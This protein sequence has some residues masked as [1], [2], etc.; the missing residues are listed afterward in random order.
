MKWLL[1]MLPSLLPAVVPHW[2]ASVCEVC[3]DSQSLECIWTSL[4]FLPV[5]KS[6]WPESARHIYSVVYVP[7]VS[8]LRGIFALLDHFTDG[9]LNYALPCRD[10]VLED[11]PRTQGLASNSRTAGGQNSMALALALASR[12]SGLGLELV[13]PWPRTFCPR[14]HPAPLSLRTWRNLTS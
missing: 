1:S 14:I 6:G 8:A 5:V 12:L 9:L 4:S 7:C 13:Q 10:G 3:C 2:W 11:W